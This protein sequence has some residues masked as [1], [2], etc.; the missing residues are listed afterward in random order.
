MKTQTLAAAAGSAPS[1]S[2]TSRYTSFVT[3]LVIRRRLVW[4]PAQSVG[5]AHVAFLLLLSMV[6]V[7]VVNGKSLSALYAAETNPYD[8]A[9]AAAVAEEGQLAN[10]IIRDAY[11]P[12]LDSARRERR[13]GSSSYV[14]FG[15]R[16]DG[17]EEVQ[18][19]EEENSPYGSTEIKDQVVGVLPQRHQRASSS[20]YVRFG[21]RM[22]GDSYSNCVAMTV[23]QAKNRAD[24][25]SLLVANGCI[26]RRPPYQANYVKKDSFVRFG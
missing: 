15:K 26:R 2:V 12:M 21:K 10:S 18:E 5:L 1:S 11:G 9:P 20:S 22:V 3:S 4:S 7:S 16:S 13:S 23:A 14:R 17:L 8:S 24:L 19:T 25:L 6:N